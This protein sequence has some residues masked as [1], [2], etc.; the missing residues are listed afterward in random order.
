[1]YF[2]QFKKPKLFYLFIALIITFGFVNLL[3]RAEEDYLTLPEKSI[4]V[5]NGNEVF[6]YEGYRSDNDSEGSKISVKRK[7]KKTNPLLI[8]DS[9]FTGGQTLTFK[10]LAM[11]VT[12]IVLFLL[13]IYFAVKMYMS[14][15]RFDQPGS[16]LD[17][18]AQRFNNSFSG[19]SNSSGLKLIQTLMLTPGQNIYVVEVEG[20]KL[21]VGGTQQGGVQF[22]ADLTKTNINGSL[23][24]KQIEDF[25]NQNHTKHIP[26]NFVAESLEPIKDLNPKEIETPFIPSK[27]AFKRR[28]NF[29]QSLLSKSVTEP[30]ALSRTS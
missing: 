4:E 17:N 27:Q 21:L 5:V 26:F 8:S 7:S 15:N 19:S 6:D 2:I 25:Q 20:K 18:I 14:R 16:F 12:F 24:F 30:D 1:M 29:R 28:M 9:A 11:R 22:L 10:D 23:D 3:V 13:V